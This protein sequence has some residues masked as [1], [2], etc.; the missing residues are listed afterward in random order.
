MGVKSRLQDLEQSI[1]STWH[2]KVDDV[3]RGRGRVG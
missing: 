3:I 2:A 1:E